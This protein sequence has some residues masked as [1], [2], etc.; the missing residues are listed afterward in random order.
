MVQ[1]AEKRKDASLYPCPHLLEAGEGHGLNFLPSVRGLDVLLV[2][3]C[4]PHSVAHAICL[5]PPTSALAH[6]PRGQVAFQVSP[7]Y[8]SDDP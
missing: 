1:G 2:L 7:I 3:S 5:R 8:L 6:V 4:P